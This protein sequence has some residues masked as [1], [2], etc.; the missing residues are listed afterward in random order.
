M[1]DDVLPD[2][3]CELIQRGSLSVGAANVGRSLSQSASS[4]SFVSKS[5]LGYFRRVKD[6]VAKQLNKK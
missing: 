3:A 1:V 4:T 2:Q 5:Q 6:K